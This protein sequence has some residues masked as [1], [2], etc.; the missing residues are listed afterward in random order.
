MNIEQFEI[1][2][3]DRLT[4]VPS[5][6]N[7]KAR[8]FKD[9]RRKT[10]EADEVNVRTNT[11]HVKTVNEIPVQEALIVHE[12][13]VQEV[14]NSIIKIA[15]PAQEFNLP[16]LDSEPVVD[17][18]DNVDASAIVEELSAD[19]YVDKFIKLEPDVFPVPEGVVKPDVSEHEVTAQA[20]KSPISDTYIE[21]MIASDDEDAIVLVAPKSS[22]IEMVD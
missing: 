21:E 12:P 8:Q 4:K 15:I 17:T 10:K 3:G 20:E 6:Q 19:K 1:S 2:I 13:V 16:I 22:T 18:V 7:E 9:A 11:P 14:I 5:R